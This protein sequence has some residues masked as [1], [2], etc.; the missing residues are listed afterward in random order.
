[1]NSSTTD[2]N[3]NFSFAFLQ[4]NATSDKP[5][6]KPNHFRIC[7]FFYLSSIDSTV[8]VAVSY[9]SNSI[10]IDI[11]YRHQTLNPPCNEQLSILWRPCNVLGVSLTFHHYS[12]PNYNSA[13]AIASDCTSLCKFFD[14]IIKGRDIN[15]FSWEIYSK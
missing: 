9:T 11:C 1:M 4:Y 6:G 2:L 15:A 3:G 10:E 14:V 5:R 8:L 12:R 13:N 7:I